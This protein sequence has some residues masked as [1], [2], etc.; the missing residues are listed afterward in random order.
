MVEAVVY[1]LDAAGELRDPDHSDRVF[2][3][4]VQTN[5]KVRNGL[6][7]QSVGEL[8]PQEVYSRGGGYCGGGGG[9]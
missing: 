7:I 2:F 8:V 4:S 9:I 5:N 1:E 6:Y 3:F